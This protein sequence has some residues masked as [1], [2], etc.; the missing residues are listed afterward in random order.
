MIKFLAFFK[1]KGVLC[2]ILGILFATPVNIKIIL[3][4]YKQ[5]EMTNQIL[6]AACVLNIIGMFWVMLPSVIVI[7]SKLLEIRIED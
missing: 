3:N 7:K 4:F 1:N 5:V 2:T 6:M